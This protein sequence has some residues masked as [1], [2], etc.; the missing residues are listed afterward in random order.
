MQKV[1]NFWSIVGENWPDASAEELFSGLY[2][3]I[4]QKM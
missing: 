1:D 3:M 4:F 2:H